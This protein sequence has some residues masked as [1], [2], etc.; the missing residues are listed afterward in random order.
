MRHDENR[1]ANPGLMVQLHFM[2]Q[3]SLCGYPYA[4]LGSDGR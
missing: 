4:A 2:K 3:Q 1:P